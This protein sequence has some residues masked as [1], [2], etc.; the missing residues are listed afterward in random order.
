MSQIVR[1]RHLL[2]TD[3]L[4]FAAA[5]FLA[6][7]LRFEGLAWTTPISRAVVMYA[8]MALPLKLGTCFA[9]GLYSR[10]WR[11]ASIPDM[12]K[13]LQ[14]GASLRASAACS[15]CWRCLARG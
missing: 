2:L 7:V 13:M 8:G 12:V 11:Q 5:P 14:A 4:L 10:L 9:F 6:C 15:A 1:N 3:L